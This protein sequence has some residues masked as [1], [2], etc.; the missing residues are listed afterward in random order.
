[1]QQ[2]GVQPNTVTFVGVLNA[3][4]SIMALEEAGMLMNRSFKVA[5]NQ[6]LSWGVA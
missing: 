3:C 4:A 6:M 1:M 2:E 5:V